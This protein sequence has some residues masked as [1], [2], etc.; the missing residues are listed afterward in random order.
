MY[1][2]IPRGGQQIDDARKRRVF[3][4]HAV[5]R[6]KMLPEDTFD[7]IHCAAQHRHRPGRHAV[8]LELGGRKGGKTRV[9]GL[10]T[11]QP[12]SA[13]DEVNRRLEGSQQG[14][15]GIARRQ[16]NR[17]GRYGGPRA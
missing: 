9:I 14:W 10:V 16:V 6:S 4:R 5:A 13:L 2:P 15:I 7:R 12:R 3:N 8:S 17:P 1:G 11:V